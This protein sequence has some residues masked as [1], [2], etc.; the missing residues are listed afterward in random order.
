MQPGGQRSA[1]A[2]G[3][4]RQSAP[5]A[6]DTVEQ[7]VLGLTK[8]VMA[9]RLP[10]AVA[11]KHALHLPTHRCAHHDHALHYQGHAFD[12]LKRTLPRTWAAA[13]CRARRC[14]TS[15][16]TRCSCSSMHTSMAQAAWEGGP[17]PIWYQMLETCG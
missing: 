2:A 3:A 11:C 5:L 15:C 16:V 13:F 4:A 9:Q 17:Q 14:R 1:H 7:H 6:L 8:D 12:W 10:W